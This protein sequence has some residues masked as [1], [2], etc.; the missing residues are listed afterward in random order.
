MSYIGYSSISSHIRYSLSWDSVLLIGLHLKL[1][2]SIQSCIV[3]CTM[4]YHG[5]LANHHCDIAGLNLTLQSYLWFWPFCSLELIVTCACLSQ[6]VFYL[7]FGFHLICG[8]WQ[9]FNHPTLNPCHSLKRPQ[10]SHCLLSNVCYNKS[11][12]RSV[13]A[14]GFTSSVS[15]I[16]P[17][18][19]CRWQKPPVGFRNKL[20]HG[21]LILPCSEQGKCWK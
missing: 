7:Q 13:F 19:A 5:D 3:M 10:P 11:W 17:V 4:S 15:T 12:I 1:N 20:T 14:F 9:P 18:P 16:S 2:M 8:P 6:P 21:G